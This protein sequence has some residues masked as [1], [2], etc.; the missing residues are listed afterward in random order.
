MTHAS[1]YNR[2]LF[3]LKVQGRR[4]GLRNPECGCKTWL[5]FGWAECW[6]LWRSGQAGICT[7]LKEKRT[8]PYIALFN[9]SSFASLLYNN[10][11]NIF[12][13][14]T[15]THTHKPARKEAR[16]ITWDPIQ[17]SPRNRMPTRENTWSLPDSS[18]SVWVEFLGAKAVTVMSGH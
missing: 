12:C 4:K 5:W 8:L 13:L 11:G 18:A 3:S 6:A 7:E 10:G 16:Y 15:F 1:R 14:V 9:W 17:Q 2:V